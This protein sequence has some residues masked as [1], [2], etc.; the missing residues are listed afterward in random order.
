MTPP[1]LGPGSSPLPA[2]HNAHV[3]VCSPYQRL[4]IFRFKSFETQT[5]GK[6]DK[7]DRI[8]SFISLLCAL[9]LGWFINNWSRLFTLCYFCSYGVIKAFFLEN[10]VIWVICPYV[11][12]LI[13]GIRC[14]QKLHFE[15]PCLDMAK[16]IALSIV[17]DFLMDDLTGFKY[18]KM[19]TDRKSGKL[20]TLIWGNL[21]MLL[22]CYSC[23]FVHYCV[24]ILCFCSLRVPTPLFPEF[25]LLWLQ[26][27][28]PHHSDINPATS[29]MT[30]LC[31]GLIAYIPYF[32]SLLLLHERTL[33]CGLFVFKSPSPFWK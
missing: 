20:H 18:F 23:F 21:L 30:L 4:L 25:K 7:S 1:G 11:V 28:L 10:V 2:W 19:P 9:Q 33:I 16:I 5:D 32:F 6:N 31:L 17:Y 13:L 14:K 24:K 12:L 8:S 22:R 29:L 27:T 3:L 15:L 26:D